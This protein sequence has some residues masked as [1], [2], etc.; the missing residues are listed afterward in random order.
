MDNSETSQYE[1]KIVDLEQQLTNAIRMIT[2]LINKQ[3]GR[4]SVSDK[5]LVESGG[6]ILNSYVEEATREMVVST[7]KVD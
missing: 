4:V 7:Y 2:I 5:E 3:G 1:L 6:Y